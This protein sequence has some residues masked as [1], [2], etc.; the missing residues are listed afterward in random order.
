MCKARSVFGPAATVHLAGAAGLARHGHAAHNA[1]Q[2]HP[3]APKL[4]RVG[5]PC[6]ATYTVGVLWLRLN[7]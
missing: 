5:R 3:T 7:T 4:G 6:G 1:A 2:G